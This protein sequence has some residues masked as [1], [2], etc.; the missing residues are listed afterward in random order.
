MDLA[1]VTCFR[2]QQDGHLSRDCPE[3]T[4]HRTAPPAA[5]P[6]ATAV[7][8]YQPP[9]PPPR[10]PDHEI[11][12][13]APHAAAL[14]ALMGWPDGGALEEA[15]KQAKAAEQVNESRASRFAAL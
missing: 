14:R 6:P 3:R 12:D 4:P 2:C 11:A 9:P 10:R 8:T 15:R 13:P 5:W 1:N 7:P